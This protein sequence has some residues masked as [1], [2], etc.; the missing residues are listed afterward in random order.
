[1]NL[2][3]SITDTHTKG[4]HLSFENRV[5]I[6][7]LCKEGYSM[8]AIARKLN[9]SPSTIKY[10]IDRGTVTLYNGNVK[11]YHAKAGQEAYNRHRLNS[12]RKPHYLLK[13]HFI[14]YVQEHFFN[15]GWS[16]DACVGR[17][18]ATG[19]F[20]R[21]QIVCTRTLYR[22]VDSGLLQ[23]QNT[24]LPEKLTRNTKTK[25]I[26]ANKKKLGRSIEDRPKYIDQRKEF[27]HWEC[28][29]VL[30]HKT[31]DDEVLL[32]LYE[33]MTR[34]FMIVP[35]PDKTAGSVMTAFNN[36]KAQY[37]EHWNEVFKTVTTDNGSEFA[38]LSQLEDI[39]N[40]LVYYAHPYTSCDKGGVECHN[41][42]IR[43]FIPKGEYVKNYS[44]DDI[45]SIEL[46]IN[47][48]PRKVLSYH[49]PDELFERRLDSI[50]RI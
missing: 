43:R 13:K 2:L 29:L 38:D 35:I 14:D 50:Y 41:R 7:T 47:D 40:T 12:G 27:G 9:C 45:F 22:Y 44:L 25:R 3:H 11:R 42:L 8:R 36:L 17:S 16:L 31:K 34:K 24:D 39:S 10:E 28:D 21:N 46:W 49:T 32:T 6:Q 18:L 19:L 15:S 20:T 4:K 23:I 30:G 48:L 26:R 5:E 1:M 37:Q 33:R